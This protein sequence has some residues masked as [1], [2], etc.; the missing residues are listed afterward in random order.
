MTSDGSTKRESKT[1]TYGIAQPSGGV[2]DGACIN[3]C[4]PCPAKQHV[5]PK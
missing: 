2:K 3:V 5:D 4:R 1:M